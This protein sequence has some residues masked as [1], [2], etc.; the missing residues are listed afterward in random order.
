MYPVNQAWRSG[1]RERPMAWL[2]GSLRPTQNPS[3]NRPYPPYSLV[4]LTPL[5]HLGKLVSHWSLWF[6]V[7]GTMCG[8]VSVLVC[9]STDGDS[10]SLGWLTIS[11]PKSMSCRLRF[12]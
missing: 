6:V 3:L 2:A 4:T 5:I 12:L 7:I 10:G 9:D 11:L 1:S 8:Q